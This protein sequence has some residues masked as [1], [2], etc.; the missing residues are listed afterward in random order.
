LTQEDLQELISE[1]QQHQRELDDIEVK[2]AEKGTP[3]RL[4]EPIF[5]FANSTRGVILFELIN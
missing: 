4:Y 5:A 1:V 2:S 3:Q